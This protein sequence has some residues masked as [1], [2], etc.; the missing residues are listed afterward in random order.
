MEETDRLDRLPVP[1]KAKISVSLRFY[2]HRH[3]CQSFGVGSVLGRCWETLAQYGASTKC[4]LGTSGDK[5]SRDQTVRR[6]TLIPSP[7]NHGHL[8]WFLLYWGYCIH[9]GATVKCR[10]QTE[11]A[12]QAE[13]MA[14]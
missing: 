3:S 1:S 8:I 5:S 10:S 11:L 9:I 4:M 13:I 14:N 6:M 7:I 12:A 2:G